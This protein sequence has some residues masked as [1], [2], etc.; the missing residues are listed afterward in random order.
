MDTTKT[1]TS[2]TTN[3][4]GFPPVPPKARQ[5]ASCDRKT[6][7]LSALRYSLRTRKTILVF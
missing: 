3:N 5:Q 7:S 1:N 2:S 4:A 6:L